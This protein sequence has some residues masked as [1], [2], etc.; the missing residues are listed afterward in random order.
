MKVIT[1]ESVLKLA[2]SNPWIA[3]YLPDKADLEQDYL[4]R[5]FLFTIV[6]TLEPTYFKRALAEYHEYIQKEKLKKPKNVIE[7]DSE[8][9]KILKNYRD[10]SYQKNKKKSRR[11]V[12]HLRIDKMK[13]K[14]C[15]RIE[16]PDM[17]TSLSNVVAP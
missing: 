4:P 14:R 9:L 2:L 11:V 15:A 5:D 6:N 16:K 10:N 13:R 3:R 7:V 12:G 1:V 17:Q 8:M